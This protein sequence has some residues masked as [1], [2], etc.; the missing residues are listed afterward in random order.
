MYPKPWL[1]AIPSK[2]EIRRWT[3]VQHDLALKDPSLPGKTKAAFTVLVK[4]C[5][6]QGWATAKLKLIAAKCGMAL[7]TLRRILLPLKGK[8]LWW[9]RTGR[10]NE[11][12]LFPPASEHSECSEVSTRSEPVPITSESSSEKAAAPEPE[13]PPVI[14]AAEPELVNQVC[15]ELAQRGFTPIK[16]ILQAALAGVTP[17]HAGYTLWR[18]FRKRAEGV[19]LFVAMLSDPP[20]PVVKP[21]EPEP[22]PTF[23]CPHCYDEGVVFHD[24]DGKFISHEGVPCWACKSRDL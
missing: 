22:M 19:G 8:Y 13:P 7:S 5:Y 17:E 10:G 6:R 14:A 11:W 23:N 18:F 21:P 16:R 4:M 12:S 1:S 24:E 20:L 2:E 15:T 9:W 3:S